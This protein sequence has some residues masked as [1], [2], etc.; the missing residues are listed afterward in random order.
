M[1]GRIL[2]GDFL[3]FVFYRYLARWSTTMLT[4]C[5][6]IDNEKFSSRHEV[7][8]AYVHADQIARRLINSAYIAC[9]ITKSVVMWI[10]CR[11]L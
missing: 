3:L 6:T 2:H 4:I 5:V 11:W 9:G 10:A 7:A 1:M 8:V